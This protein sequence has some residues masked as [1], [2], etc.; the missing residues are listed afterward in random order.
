M[1]VGCLS[2]NCIF[3][4]VVKAFEIGESW[5]IVWTLRL[6]CSAAVSFLNINIRSDNIDTRKVGFIL[7]KD[8]PNRLLA[9]HKNLQ[10]SLNQCRK[11]V[12][13]LNVYFASSIATAILP[14]TSPTGTAIFLSAISNVIK[15]R[16]SWGIVAFSRFTYGIPK[17]EKWRELNFVVQNFIFNEIRN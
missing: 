2:A 15:S 10:R 14:C 16:V 4:V 3:G 8:V 17:R 5:T 6:A 13:R 9:R 1:N 12:D 11:I 7:I